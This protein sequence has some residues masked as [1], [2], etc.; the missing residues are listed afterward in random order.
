MF[1]TGIEDKHSQLP[2]MATLEIWRL[3]CLISGHA[4]KTRLYEAHWQFGHPRVHRNHFYPVG[5]V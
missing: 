2:L 5:T 4:R 1:W 3:V